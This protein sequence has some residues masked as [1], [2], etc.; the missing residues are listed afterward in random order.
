MQRSP[1]RISRRRFSKYL[2]LTESISRTRPQQSRLGVIMAMEL[3][4]DLFMAF[5]PFPSDVSFFFLLSNLFKFFFFILF[6]FFTPTLD[7]R[8]FKIRRTSG[9]P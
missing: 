4:L 6:F 8:S 1:E 9:R 5:K 3:C 2:N 7:S